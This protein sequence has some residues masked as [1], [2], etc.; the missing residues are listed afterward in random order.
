VDLPDPH[1]GAGEVRIAVRAAG[2]NASDWKKRQFSLH[3]G[4]TF[5]LADVAEAHRVGESGRVRGK[6][7][8]LVD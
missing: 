1:A 6:L 7:V 2:V 3:V 4:Q 8:L 5:S